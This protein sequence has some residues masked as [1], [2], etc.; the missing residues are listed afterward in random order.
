MSLISR[1][2][3]SIGIAASLALLGNATTA[4]AARGLRPR[5]P[6]PTGPYELGTTEMH[7]VDT[8][9]T[10]PWVANRPRELMIS[11]W[12]PARPSSHEPTA[13]YAGANVAPQLASQLAGFLGLAGDT[14]DLA[15]TTTHAHRGAKALGRHPVLLCS[16]AL[17][18][19]RTVGTYQAEEL[20][21]RGYVVVT[22]DHTYETPVEFP[23]GR[24]TGVEAPLWHETFKDREIPVR[25]ADT[26]FVLD[27]LERIANGG[28]PDAENR[29][30]PRGLR[31]ALDLRR[32]GMYGHSLGGF[33]AAEAMLVD[34]R[35]DVGVNLDGSMKY[36][37]DDGSYDLSEVVQR[38]LTRPFLLFGGGT[39]SHLDDPAWAAFWLNQRAW[40]LDLNLPT[41]SHGAF[42][43]HQIVLPPLAKANGIPHEVITQALGAIEPAR[44]VTAVGSYLGAYFDQFLRGRPQPMLWRESPR[45]PEVAFVR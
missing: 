35:I 4:N 32:M 15:G 37:R 42:A 28:N 39:H 20:A 9:R 40:K 21:S 29:Q 16:P 31:G 33:T 1:R 18:A 23:G 11:V 12:Y 13:P 24:V 25:V 19:S 7:L 38:G 14:L 6:E 3:V 45:F 41:G 36:E 26:R 44:A 27:A 2:T 22:I 5:L 8:S 17:G 34:R 10:D 30:L 43:D